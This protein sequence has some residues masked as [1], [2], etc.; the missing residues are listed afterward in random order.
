MIEPQTRSISSPIHHQKGVYLY[1]MKYYAI[2]KTFTITPKSPTKILSN[3]T[4]KCFSDEVSIGLNWDIFSYE[5][6]LVHRYL[7]R[8]NK[9]IKYEKITREQKYYLL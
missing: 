6:C 7:N 3:N 1:H 5:V 2:K 8:S 4:R 9:K